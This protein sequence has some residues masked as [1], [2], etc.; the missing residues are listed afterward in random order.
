[1]DE[2]QRAMPGD[3]FM[4]ITIVFGQNKTMFV[5]KEDQC[6]PVFPLVNILTLERDKLPCNTSNP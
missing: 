2:T 3:I 6:S 4:L 1:M 5:E